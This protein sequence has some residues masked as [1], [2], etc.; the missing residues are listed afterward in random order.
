MSNLS[1][2]NSLIGDIELLEEG[3]TSSKSV[4]LEGKGS[5]SELRI[6]D[7]DFSDDLS[8][9][10]TFHCEFYLTSIRDMSQCKD[11]N[12]L[13]NEQKCMRFGRPD[14]PSIFQ[15]VESLCESE[16]VSRVAVVSCGPLSM[17]NEVALLSSKQRASGIQFDHHEE[18][19]D[20]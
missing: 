7:I 18:L 14:L 16:Q 11:A 6:T 15:R 2:T 4:H 3:E 19:F 8:V 13:P 5:R 17:M 9:P 20:F 1:T 12:I 10:T